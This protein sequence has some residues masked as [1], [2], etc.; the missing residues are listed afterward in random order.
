MSITLPGDLNAIPVLQ[1]WLSRQN[2]L[3]SQNASFY[4]P[5]IRL[6]EADVANFATLTTVTAPTLRSTAF[7]G[8]VNIVGNL[9]LFPSA[10]GTLELAAA[11]GVIGLQ[12][13][14][15]TQVLIDGKFVPVTAWTTA[16][17]NLSDADPSKLPGVASPNAYQA[18]VGNTEIALRQTLVNPFLNLNPSFQET[19]SFSGA[20]GTVQIQQA[21]HGVGLLHADDPNPVRLY[22][23]GEI[24]QR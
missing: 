10:K 1:A 22:A 5:W 2:L 7:A 24:S 15:K 13:S 6:A 19:G 11:G 3:T 9:T 16:S 20:A 8:G 14:G 18:L 12:P 17:V 23:P 21:L 4:E